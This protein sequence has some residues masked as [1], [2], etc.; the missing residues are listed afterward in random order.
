[1]AVSY[2]FR[3]IFIENKCEQK[4]MV[5]KLCIFLLF[6]CIAGLVSM[7]SMAIGGKGIDLMANPRFQQNPHAIHCIAHIANKYLRFEPARG[8]TKLMIYFTKKTNILS[9]LLAKHMMNNF[10]YKWNIHTKSIH[11]ENRSYTPKI[12]FKTSNYFLFINETSEVATTL[13]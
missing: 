13:R 2:L 10:G 4:K 9:N 8:T 3:K 1:M 6:V 5:R 11:T 12:R 7:Q